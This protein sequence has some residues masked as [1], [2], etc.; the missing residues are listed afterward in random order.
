VPY[1]ECADALFSAI[2]RFLNDTPAE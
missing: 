1:V 2:R